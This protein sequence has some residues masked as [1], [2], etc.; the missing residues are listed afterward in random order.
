MEEFFRRARKNKLIAECVEELYE[1]W[2]ELGKPEP[3]EGPSTE[4]RGAPAFLHEDEIEGL[5]PE[6]TERE[7]QRYNDSLVQL[8]ELCDI[9]HIGNGA[10]YTQYN[11]GTNEWQ[12][13]QEKS[14]EIARDYFTNYMFDFFVDTL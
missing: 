10:W 6:D 4:F 11:E 2:V 5:S 13:Y 7:V 9:R 14:W 1:L 8:L 3:P 12:E